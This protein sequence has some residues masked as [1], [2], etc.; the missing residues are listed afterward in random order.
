MK[1]LA[2]ADVPHSAL[3]APRL[4]N[5][6]AEIDYQGLLDFVHCGL[7]TASCPTYL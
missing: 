3:R 5:P 4:P 6:G 2:A 7:C 1:D